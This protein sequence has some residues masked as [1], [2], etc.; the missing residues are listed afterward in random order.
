MGCTVGKPYNF[1]SS[2]QITPDPLFFF[3]FL[4]AL[5]ADH[6]LTVGILYKFVVP[7]YAEG[8]GFW[9]PTVWNIGVKSIGYTTDR[10]TNKSGI[11]FA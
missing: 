5:N 1:T 4:L 6:R 2:H 10:R 7:A 3:V 8:R 11:S 9:W